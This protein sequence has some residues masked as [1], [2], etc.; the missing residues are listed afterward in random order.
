MLYPTFLY[1]LKIVK[2][3]KTEVEEIE[4]NIAETDAINKEA[5]EE[6]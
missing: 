3:L 4:Q 1:H 6:E 2:S 5:R